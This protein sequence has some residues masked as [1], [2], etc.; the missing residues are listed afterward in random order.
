METFK[1][2]K[3]VNQ[4]DLK[5]IRKMRRLYRKTKKSSR[6]HNQMRYKAASNFVQQLT[7]HDHQAH[8]HRGESSKPTTKSKPFWSWLKIKKNDNEIAQSYH[9]GKTYA[10]DGEKAQVLNEC[11][12]SVSSCFVRARGV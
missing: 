2:A 1:G 11:S 12:Q 10:S 5:A 6:D 8:D 4:V 7:Q 3:V 9:D